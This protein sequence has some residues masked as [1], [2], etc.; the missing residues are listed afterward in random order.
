MNPH[1]VFYKATLKLKIKA[2]KILRQTKKAQR[3]RI[4]NPKAANPKS[5]I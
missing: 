3:K 5:K 1:S 4:Y 2:T